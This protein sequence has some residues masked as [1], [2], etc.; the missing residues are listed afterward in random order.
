[1]KIKNH[2]VVLLFSAGGSSSMWF[3]QIRSFKEKFS[4]LLIDLSGHG[5]SKSRFDENSKQGYTF[6]LITKDI[7]EVVNYLSIKISHFV[8]VSLGSIFI[9][10]LAVSYPNSS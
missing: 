10:V 6:E 2:Q 3:R 4:V 1:M 7:A 9:R 5:K 8:G